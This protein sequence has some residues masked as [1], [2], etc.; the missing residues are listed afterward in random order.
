MW[1]A[2]SGTCPG[3]PAYVVPHLGSDCGPYVDPPRLVTGLRGSPL[4]VLLPLDRKKAP[5]GR[6]GRSEPYTEARRSLLQRKRAVRSTQ[7]SRCVHD[8]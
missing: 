8:A 5:S 4:V 3:R 7:P 6:V 1:H 2:D